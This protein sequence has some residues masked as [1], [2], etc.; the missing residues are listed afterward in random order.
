MITRNTTTDTQPLRVT[1]I[2]THDIPPALAPD[3]NRL[4]AGMPLRSWEWYA[5]WWK[6]YRQSSFDLRLLIVHDAQ[7]NV[8]GIAP[9]YRCTSLMSGK[10]FRF[11]ADNEVCTDYQTILCSVLDQSAVADAIGNW[12]LTDGRNQ[13]DMFDWNGTEINDPVLNH[14][15]EVLVAGGATIFHQPL[16]SAWRLALTSTWDELLKTRLSKSRRE[17]VRSLDKKYVRTGRARVEILTDPRDLEVH[18][19]RLIELHQARRH[20]LG[21]AGRF[22]E[23]SF[24]NFHREVLTESLT[25]GNAYLQTLWIDDVA[26]MVE[27]SFR[28]TEGVMF[29][30]G[31]M[32]PASSQHRP[33]WLNFLFSI[34]R[35]I[36]RG[37]SY[38]DFL[39]GDEPYKSSWGAE[40]IG[41]R[42]TRIT[43]GKAIPR[44]RNTVW[45]ASRTLHHWAMQKLGTTAKKPT[46]S[47]D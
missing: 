37:H 41:L 1:L 15:T 23:E 17:K 36:E 22:G 29:Y 21:E 45:H 7:K 46:P 2:D 44:L 18:Y 47:E 14:L 33:G 35:A 12:L 32:N 16:D 3:W 38:F 13:W 40:P 6:S 30:Q 10:A 34:Q 26:A 24:I 28:S 42:R 43:A 9:W 5:A 11:L 27:Y 20:E 8:L 31:G 25:N 19:A 4:A 39:R